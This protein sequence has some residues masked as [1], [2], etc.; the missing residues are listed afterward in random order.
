[1]TRN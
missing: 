1:L